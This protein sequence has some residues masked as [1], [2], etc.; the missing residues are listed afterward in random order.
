MLS[1]NFMPGA[2][3][4]ESS[5]MNH[6]GS[7]FMLRTE[8][9]ETGTVGRVAGCAAREPNEV[10]PSSDRVARQG[11]SNQSKDDSER[12]LL[13]GRGMKSRG[14]RWAACVATR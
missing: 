13:V 7:N 4:P 6:T 2:G 3:G 5:T 8:K 10:G 14:R 1:F 11:D 12:Q 9:A